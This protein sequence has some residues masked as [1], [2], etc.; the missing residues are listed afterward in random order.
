MRPGQA[1]SKIVTL[2]YRDL[3]WPKPR[4][5]MYSSS[6]FASHPWTLVTIVTPRPFLVSCCTISWVLDL[7]GVEIAGKF[8]RK[9]TEVGGTGTTLH[10]QAWAAGQCGN[11]FQIEHMESTYKLTTQ[12]EYCNWR[13]ISVV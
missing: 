3:P 11:E 12:L 5:H 8:V 2:I 7:S 10:Y 9:P 1:V 4:P 6:E 13:I